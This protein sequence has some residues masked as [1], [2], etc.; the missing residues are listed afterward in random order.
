MFGG[1]PEPESDPLEPFDNLRKADP[2]LWNKVHP[3]E[4]TKLYL[5]YIVSKDQVAGELS[6]MNHCGMKF[7]NN[8][9]I[10]GDPQRPFVV[11]HS[12]NRD[13]LFVPTCSATLSVR[14]RN[15]AESCKATILYP[16]NTY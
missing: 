8:Y 12:F 15:I 5:P 11:L 14:D 16:A 6:M 13:M 4:I 1:C 7:R 10:S 3:Y 2:E 9:Y